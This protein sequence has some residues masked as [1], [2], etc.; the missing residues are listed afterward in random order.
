MSF[1]LA[2]LLAAAK[3]PSDG[4][5]APKLSLTIR[6]TNAE[7]RAGDEISIEFEITNKGTNDYEYAN[8]TYDRSGRMDEYALVAKTASG[9]SVPD[10]RA[11]N[12]SGW[13]GGGLHS[14]RI[15]HPGESA[16]QVIPLNRW[17]LIK[18]PGQY[19]VVGT[20]LSALYSTN[21]IVVSSTPISITVLPRSEAELDAYIGG[22]SNQLAVLK[23]GKDFGHRGEKDALVMKLMFT[24]SPK[25]VPSVLDAMYEADRGGFWESEALQFYVPH[26]DN[27]KREIFL[28]ATKRGLASGMQSVLA[29]YGC[30]RDDFLPLIRA[31][32]AQ[33]N[34]LSWQAG[35]TAAQQYGDDEFAP[36]LIALATR[37]DTSA[38]MQAIYALASNR[39]DEGVK[40]LRK[41]LADPDKNIRTTVESALQAA[42]CY[43]GIWQ[44]RPLK[45]EDF[46]KKY[47][48]P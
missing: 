38:R 1:S 29:S 14:P 37:P 15:L 44:G 9:Q 30:N 7:L 22:L 19:E 26:S 46:D 41:L 28:V 39:T 20:Y 2:V 17:A 35:A 36:R 10:P 48:Q 40:V 6:C 5:V 16:T 11:P 47:Q 25:I 3:E 27:V 32:L 13:M 21:S 42:Y 45:A 18:E 24:C 8:R 33:E 4:V 31:S 12:K 23:P 34:P 43:R